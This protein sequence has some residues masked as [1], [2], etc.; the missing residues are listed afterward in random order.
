MSDIAEDKFST[1]KLLQGHYEAGRLPTDFS[2]EQ[3]VPD[4]GFNILN[5]LGLLYRP[6]VDEERLAA[7]QK[8]PD[9][10]SGKKFA[11]CL[12]H[13]VDFVSARSV[14]QHV[15]SL[16]RDARVAGGRAKIDMLRALA[17]NMFQVARASFWSREDPFHR[18]ERWLEVESNVGAHSTF[19][20]LPE[21]VGKPHYT[22]GAYRY[23]DIVRFDGQRCNVA[24]M[25]REI[26]QRGWE[27]GLHAS[28]YAFDDSDELERQKEQLEETVGHEITSIRQHFLH[29]DIRTTP[30]AQATAG[31][32]YDSSLGFNANVGFRFGTAHPWYLHDL[33]SE[34]ELSLLEIPLIIQDIG[35]LGPTKG[36][37]LDE[38]MAFRYVRQLAEVTERVGGV[39][40]LLWHPNAITS[41]ADWN[42]YLRALEELTTRGAWLASVDEV[43]K[44][45]EARSE[46]A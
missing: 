11:A 1:T 14:R 7:G 17:Q 29:Y 32:K 23:S 41:P 13:D 4:F 8:R 19:F 20:F 39:L 27:V 35:L 18:F 30:R 15:R 5:P 43:G 16:F 28:W 46:T 12:T 6:I 37:R 21:F 45:W 44:W 26:D 40:T 2:P 3:A 22:D 25:I 38:E 24:E 31:F 33:E 34:S 10:P 36:L 42:V 9:W